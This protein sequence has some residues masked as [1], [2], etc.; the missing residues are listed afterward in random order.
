MKYLKLFEDINNDFTKTDSSTFWASI[1]NAIPL[2]NE[3]ISFLSKK[4]FSGN[5]TM[6]ST[7]MI[8]QDND[9]YIIAVVKTDDDWYYVMKDYYSKVSVDKSTEFYKCDQF[10]GLKNCLTDIN[11]MVK[12][13]YTMSEYGYELVNELPNID[14]MT[15]YT[16]SEITKL[17]TFGINTISSLVQHWSP[18]HPVNKKELRYY[19]DNNDEWYYIE[20]YMPFKA[21]TRKFYKCDQW[22]GLL[23]CLKKEFNLG[24]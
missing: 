10:I 8:K 20:S 16:D 13:S 14:D 21:E 22:D 18:L 11:V 6:M 3:D 5:S 4:G 9:Q 23:N 12:E 15:E 1:K 17:S 24:C 7:N 19:K 2:N